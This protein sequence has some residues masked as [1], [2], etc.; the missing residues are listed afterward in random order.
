[1]YVCRTRACATR[2]LRVPAFIVALAHL[3]ETVTMGFHFFFF[4]TFFNESDKYIY[5]GMRGHFMCVAV[6]CVGTV[7]VCRASMLRTREAVR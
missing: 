1:M 2:I 7:G 6:G 5:P 4:F 3:L